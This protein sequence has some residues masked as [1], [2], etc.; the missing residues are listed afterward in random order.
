VG[1]LALEQ[2]APPGGERGWRFVE[3]RGRHRLL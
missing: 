3:R 1:V 2:Q